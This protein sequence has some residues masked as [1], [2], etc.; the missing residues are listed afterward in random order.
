MIASDWMEYRALGTQI[1]YKTFV[2][3]VHD[4]QVSDTNDG[5]IFQDDQR[6]AISQWQLY[7]ATEQSKLSD[8]HCRAN[9]ADSR[10]SIVAPVTKATTGNAHSK[11]H[12]PTDGPQARTSVRKK[13]MTPGRAG[14]AAG[15]QTRK[16]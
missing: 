13:S 15:W 1:D 8:A 2:H 11:A 5:I 3:F 9:A 7:R 10:S 6:P 14:K 12:D 4:T 16:R